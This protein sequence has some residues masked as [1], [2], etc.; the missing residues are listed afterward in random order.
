[1]AEKSRP[2]PFILLVEE[3]RAP[4]GVYRDYRWVAE[5]DSGRLY[6]FWIAGDLPR[7]EDAYRWAAEHDLRRVLNGKTPRLFSHFEPRPEPDGART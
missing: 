7:A 3:R 1:M 2:V 5:C 6:S 4:N